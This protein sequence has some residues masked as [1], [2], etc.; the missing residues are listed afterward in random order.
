MSNVEGWIRLIVGKKNSV[1]SRSITNPTRNT[2][3]RKKHFM[4]GE[5]PAGSRIMGPNEVIL[6]VT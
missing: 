3:R 6:L 4:N 2:P 5:R 1:K